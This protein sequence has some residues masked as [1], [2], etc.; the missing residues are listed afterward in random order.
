MS[1]HINKSIEIVH[2]E[3][4]DSYRFL[5]DDEYGTVLFI[6]SESKRSIYIPQSALQHVIDALTELK[7]PPND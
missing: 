3:F 1:Y 6:D 5:Y 7:Q 4:G 2:D